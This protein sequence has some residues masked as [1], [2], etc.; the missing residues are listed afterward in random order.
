[1]GLGLSG[2]I[3]LSDVLISDVIDEDEL[4]TNTR[5]EGMYFG[6]NAFVTRFAIA[7]EAL[8]I[9]PIFMFTNYNPYVFTQ[10]R[11]FLFGLRVLISGLPILALILAFIIMR[12]YPLDRAR[13]QRIKSDLEELHRQ[14]GVNISTNCSET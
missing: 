1:M 7:L 3:L 2:I 8:C 12:F 6:V 10:T 4:K 5:R 9:G 13:L 11:E 14:K